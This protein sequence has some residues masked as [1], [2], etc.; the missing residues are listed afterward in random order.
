MVYNMNQIT[1]LPPRYK[2]EELI[3]EAELQGPEEKLLIRFQTPR[4]VAAK[5]EITKRADPFVLAFCFRLMADG[6]PVKING[7]V[8]TVLLRNIEQFMQIW[9]AWRPEKYRAVHIEAEEEINDITTDIGQPALLCFS[10][11]VDSCYSAWRHH[12]G[13]AGRS[14]L[15]VNA[16]IFVHGADIRLNQKEIYKQQF[17]K[18]EKI[19][20]DLGMELICVRT[21]ARHSEVDWEDA[22]ASILAGTM[23]LF[24]N[25]GTG[26]LA[27]SMPFQ[28]FGC[29]WGSTPWTDHLLSSGRFRIACD[30]ANYPR[31]EKI[32]QMC[33]WATMLQ[34]LHVCW[35]GQ[36]ST[37]N[38]CKCEKCI[39]TI[40][41]FIAA[42]SEQPPCFPKKITPD[43]VLKIKLSHNLLIQA[44]GKVYRQ[45][46]KNSHS[47]EPVFKALN[48]NLRR[49]RLLRRL[50]SL[51]MQI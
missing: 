8:S 48:R 46:S 42:G 20:R 9:Q 17:E 24:E 28:W 15:P 44:N 4:K 43:D 25:F 7:P 49:H 12:H 3:L 18:N 29:K 51:F 27:S 32:E 21:N 19:L 30:G 41:S 47:Q 11:G 2:D 36:D 13:L 1:L 6:L 23:M 16:G 22:H 14:N 26:L 34:N 45:A 31:V 40:L 35:E 10:G 38:C 5:Y 33:D 39:R 50:K 37:E